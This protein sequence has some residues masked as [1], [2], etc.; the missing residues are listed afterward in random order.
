M[1]CKEQPEEINRL[2]IEMQI[3]FLHYGLRHYLEGLNKSSTGIN[4]LID[5]ATGYEEQVVKQTKEAAIEIIQELI[6]LKGLIKMD[7]SAE[8][9]VLTLIK[10]LNKA[11]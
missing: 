8:Q 7:D 10:E 5:R 2:E 1:K 4:A 3:G 11:N 9:K 6:R